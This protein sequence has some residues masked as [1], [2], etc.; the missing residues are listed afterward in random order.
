MLEPLPHLPQYSLRSSVEIVS[1]DHLFRA[2]YP[3]DGTKPLASFSVKA[4]E[5]V[6]VQAAQQVA[7]KA[8]ENS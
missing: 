6:I 4:G 3:L 2:I 8:D 7:L 5:W 1:A